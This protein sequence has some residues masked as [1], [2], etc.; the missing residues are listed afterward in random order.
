M[1]LPILFTP[2]AEE[3]LQ[4]TV[5]FIETQWEENQQTAF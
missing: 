2:D 4:A 3:T 5:S 1:S